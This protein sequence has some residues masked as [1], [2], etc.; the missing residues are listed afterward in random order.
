[1]S[2]VHTPV[3]PDHFLPQSFQRKRTASFSVASTSLSANPRPTKAPRTSSVMG[4]RRTES[5]LT[6]PTVASTSVAIISAQGTCRTSQ[7]SVSTVPYQQ[8]LQYYKDQRQRRKA[9]TRANLNLEPITIRTRLERTHSQPQ[10]HPC[11][12]QQPQPPSYISTSPPSSRSR[13]LTRTATLLD[14]TT[15]A[16]D[17]SASSASEPTSSPTPFRVPPSLRASSPLSPKRHLLPGRPVF[18]RSKQEPDLYRLAIKTCMRYSPEGQKILRMGPRLAL[19]ILT[20]TQDLER[21]VAEQESREDVPMEDRPAA[22]ETTT[23]NGTSS[24]PPT[25][26]NSWVDLRY[27]DWEMVDCNA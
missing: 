4:L 12:S 21:I 22:A 26:S 2:L 24:G 10:P 25:L 3:V 13:S 9:A 23:D 19:S 18:P 16:V 17:A 7:P 15:S 6:L 27:D 11:Q 1:M 20:A 8:S 5:Y 14:V